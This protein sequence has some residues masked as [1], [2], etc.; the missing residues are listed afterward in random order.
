MKSP[1]YQSLVRAQYVSA[2]PD[3]WDLHSAYLIVQP[4]ALEKRAPRLN[5][6][7]C[8]YDVIISA[9]RA[10]SHLLPFVV[11]LLASALSG[12]AQVTRQRFTRPSVPPPTGLQ[13][14]PACPHT[15]TVTWS[16]F[17]TET[18]WHGFTDEI[19]A[20]TCTSTFYSEAVHR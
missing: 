1:A 9:L 14:P 11:V 20:I 4:E 13:W 16:P 10:G 2:V 8:P 19:A 17:C 7:K 5:Y 6:S 12:S 3:N 18:H 15:R